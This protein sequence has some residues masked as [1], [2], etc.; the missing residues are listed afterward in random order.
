MPRQA[1][2]LFLIYSLLHIGRLFEGCDDEEWSTGY[3]RI[4][5]LYFFGPSPF[6]SVTT[7]EQVAQRPPNRWTEQGR[8]HTE[9]F[10]NYSKDSRNHLWYPE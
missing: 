10:W 1:S 6:M 3:A 5:P 4:G 2:A 9:T 8:A 7:D